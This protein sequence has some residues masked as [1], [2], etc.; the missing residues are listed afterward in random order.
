MVVAYGDLR[1][2]HVFASHW[3]VC[4][5]TFGVCWQI[6]SLVGFYS[7]TGANNYGSDL[8]VFVYSN[9]CTSL[10]NGVRAESRA[11][12]IIHACVAAAVA[13]AAAFAL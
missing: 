10:E 8:S 1:S 6:L 9:Q 13:A 4:G 5:S 7:A 11:R 2:Y 3:R 12:A